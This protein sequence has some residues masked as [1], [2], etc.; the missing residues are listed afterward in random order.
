M[1]SQLIAILKIMYSIFFVAL[2][3]LSIQYE[4]AERAVWLL[5]HVTVETG[6]SAAWWTTSC[7]HH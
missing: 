2:G 1:H 4:E 5:A 6:Y 7:Y 3:S